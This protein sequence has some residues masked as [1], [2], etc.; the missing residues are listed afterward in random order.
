M[1]DIRAPRQ[2]LRWLPLVLIPVLLLAST[3]PGQYRVPAHYWLLAMAAGV[4]F[5]AGARRP[6][7]V[8]IVLSA[9]AVPMLRT[10]AWGVS[11]LV[12]YLGAVALVDVIARSHR[13]AP[14][15][16]AT[17]AWAAAVVFGHLGLHDTSIGRAS[18]VVE[19]A[20]YV[21]LPL[22]LGLYLRGQRD[23]AENLR[24]R[25]ADAEARTRI[26]ERAALARELHDVVAHHMASIIL[27]ISVAGHVVRTADPRVVAVL[28]DVRG[29]AA[30]ALT[31][32]RRLL[33][34]L[35]DPD[36][37]TVALVDPES[38]ATEIAAAV[39][40]VR[41]AGFTVEAELEPDLDGLDAITRLTLLRLVQES[42]TNVMKHADR[43]VPVRFRIGRGDGGIGVEVVSGGAAT[44]ALPGHG[45]VG[46]R[47]R[48]ALA[49]GTLAVG[50]EEANW[51]VRAW[52]P[53]RT[54]E[55]R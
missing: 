26:D 38:V 24:M 19:A 14:V 5:L 13:Q 52:L 1:I 53:E 45:I 36:L 22:L 47:E 27:R 21:G 15:W 37:G 35:R 50:A 44:A 20:A 54:G 4:V 16:V 25:A 10:P 30:D 51:V 17:G 6:L 48:A 46:M 41:A 11:G 42:L 55:L 2:L 12:P 39:D 9:L 43:A 32:I 40:R 28:D 31:N 23:L 29:T 34:A 7:T 8:S 3:Y 18:T 33:A 49:G